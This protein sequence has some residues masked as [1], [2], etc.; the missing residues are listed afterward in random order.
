MGMQFGD[1]AARVATDK[2]VS[3]DE[4]AD[5]RRL[6]WSDG[7]IGREEAEQLFGINCQLTER[8]REWADFFVEAIGEFVINGTAPRGYVSDEEGD[9]LIGSLDRDG[10]LESMAELELLVH[11][12]ERAENTPE[13]LKRYALAQIETAVLTGI[14]PTRDGGELSDTHITPAECRLVRRTIY[15]CGG[16]DPAAVSRFDA[17]MLFRL[18]DST[19]HE[20]NAPEWKDLFVKGVGNYLMGLTRPDAQLSHERMKELD[21]FMDDHSVCLGGFFGAMAK[22]TPHLANNFGRLF[23]PKAAAP[24]NFAR[25]AAGE[26][27]T[28][29]EKDWLDKEIAANGRVDELDQA[30]LD[31]ISAE[32][33]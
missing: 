1:L 14:G 19:L 12:M 9:W 23:G 26:A 4:L 29:D 8:S 28:G 24:D 10:R 5:L 3:G 7:R 15:A 21:A 13:K 11:V 30:L 31:F 22:S 33:G 18:K 32:L 2:Q 17:E 27:V 25:M 20:A 6:G 16:F